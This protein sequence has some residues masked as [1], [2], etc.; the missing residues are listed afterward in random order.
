[1]PKATVIC[2]DAIEVCRSLEAGSVNAIIID[3]PYH[4]K[5]EMGKW[6]TLPDVKALL[7]E[8]WRILPMAGF[9][10]FT[11]QMPFALDW[12]IPLHDEP[13]RF[14]N[15]IIWAKRKLGRTPGGLAR[16]H[17]TIYIY[18]KGAAEYRQVRGR[19]EDV[20]V[21]GLLAG[22]ADI[23]G[24]QRHIASLR[25]QI[26]TGK[27]DVVVRQ[28]ANR[29]EA[30]SGFDDQQGERAPELVNL[31]D[32]WSFLPENHAKHSGD[33]KHATQK[34]VLLFER[35]VELLT[36]PGEVVLDCFGG[37]GTTAEAALN[38]GRDCILSEINPEY[39]DM[40]RKRLSEPRSE[41]MFGS[42]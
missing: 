28:A 27:P 2:G 8:F 12:L 29:H 30:H 32:V 21:P 31:T 25:H 38:V 35:L 22:T 4:H 42:F 23:E 9:L 7:K 19:F 39:C 11:H 10:A 33:Y 36:S 41:L 17:E 18:S 16:C 13:F 3:P 15:E 5:G 20:K 40:V 37:S 34:P 24:I 26:K 14:R 1:M 6:D